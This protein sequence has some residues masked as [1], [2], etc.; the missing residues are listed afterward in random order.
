MEYRYAI[1][2]AFYSVQDISELIK[3]RNNAYKTDREKRVITY[4]NVTDVPL[5][6]THNSYL[7]QEVSGTTTIRAVGKARYNLSNLNLRL[8]DQ[9]GLN[10]FV[11]AWEL[12]PFSFVVD[13]FVNIGDWVQAQTSSLVDLAMQRS[14]CYSIKHELRVVTKL[15]IKEVEQFIKPYPELGGSVVHEH[16]IDLDDV[17]TTELISHYERHPFH[18]GDTQ[19]VLDAFLNWKRSLDAFVLSNK[20]LIKALRSLK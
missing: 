15:R 19:I 3:E 5:I 4:N 10:P 9:V 1:M 6:N 14:F 2:P 17:L 18:A 16:P 12:I 13:W 7:Y 11:T 20:P 8:F